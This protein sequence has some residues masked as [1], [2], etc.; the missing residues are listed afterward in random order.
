MENTWAL[1][2]VDALSSVFTSSVEY[3]D[4]HRV[5]LTVIYLRQLRSI[6]SYRI[7][8][9]S[10]LNMH[11]ELLITGRELYDT[12][13]KIEPSPEAS[14]HCLRLPPFRIYAIA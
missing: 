4:G 1:S 9:L 13:L 14:G 6:F 7:V 2:T 3:A 8:G 10:V 11:D 12:V 5:G